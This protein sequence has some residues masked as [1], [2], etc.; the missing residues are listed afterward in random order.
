M[1]KHIFKVGDKVKLVAKGYWESP[2]N[3]IWEGKYGKIKGKITSTNP[4]GE[5]PINV[6]WDNG[7]ENV[8]GTKD[9]E[10]AEETI[11]ETIERITNH[12]QT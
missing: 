3:P 6:T 9:L 2:G 4:G 5:L 10:P 7:T 1:K 11:K 12:E 8:Y